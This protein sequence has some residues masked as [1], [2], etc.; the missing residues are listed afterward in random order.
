MQDSLTPRDFKLGINGDNSIVFGL[1]DDSQIITTA[2]NAIMPNGWHLI[3]ASVDGPGNSMKLYVDGNL[4]VQ[5]GYVGDV[6]T[7]IENEGY[8]RIGESLDGYLSDFKVFG[9]ALSQQEILD[10]MTTPQSSLGKNIGIQFGLNNN[11]NESSYNVF[12]QSS[13]LQG[14]GVLGQNITTQDN[15]QASLDILK[16]AMVRKDTI[17]ASLGATQNRLENTISNLQIQAENLQAAESQISD[18]DV[19]NEM[20]NFVKEQILSQ[21]ATAMLA[22]A[23]SIPKMAIQLISGG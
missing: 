3:T 5:G 10:L 11:P 20:T 4:K 12:I 14:L 9:T 16:S 21:A 1:R 22:Q 23:N 13:T 2:S 6:M 19:A 15:A 17:R 7:P 8:T 18:V